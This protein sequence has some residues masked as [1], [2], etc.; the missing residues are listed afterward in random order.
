M[1]DVNTADTSAV[2]QPNE[3]SGSTR[4]V[5][6][7]LLQ[8]GIFILILAAS[9]FIS[10]GRLDW[11]MAWVYIGVYIV[12]QGITVLVLVPKSPDLAAERAQ[13]QEGTKGWDRPLT[14]IVALYGPAAMWIVAGLD[15]RSHWSPQIPLA[16]QIAALLV[17]VL[18]SLLT[19]WAMA[20][21]K[22]FSGTVR[23]QK[24]RGHAVAT[25][26]PYQYVRH[27]GYVGGILFDLATP[28]ILGSGW[29]FI[30]AVLTVCVFIVRTALED[31]TL[32][33]ELDG[34]KGY[35]RRVRYR[36]LPGV[37]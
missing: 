19:V 30:P 14:G 17:A 22:F 7:W 13:V 11:V 24:E 23:I 35:A 16:L 28:L 1:M 34:Y 21:N 25:G 37:W 36:L 33:N 10:A 9:L 4:G 32:Q 8:I 26:G 2:G 18:G 15:K 27:P 12:S 31:R 20:S 6:K 5:L 3:K 29:A